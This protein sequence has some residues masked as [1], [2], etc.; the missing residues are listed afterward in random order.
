[1]VLSFGKCTK[2]LH[3]TYIPGRQEEACVLCLTKMRVTDVST[4]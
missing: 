1:M 2:S 3:L 4:Y